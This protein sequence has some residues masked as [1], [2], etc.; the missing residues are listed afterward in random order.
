MKLTDR[1]IQLTKAP[2]SSRIM[3]TNGNGLQLRTTQ[4]GKR[5]WSLQHRH[6][7]YMRKWL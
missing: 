1:Q 3:L 4:S 6:H 2:E 7:S 5:I